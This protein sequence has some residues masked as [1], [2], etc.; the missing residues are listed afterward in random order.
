MTSGEPAVAGALS[1]LSNERGHYAIRAPGPGRYRLAA[2]RIGVKRTIVAPFDLAEGETR[3]VTI[4]I[5]QLLYALPEVSVTTATFCIP[6]EDQ[7]GRVASL[8]EE[9]R[10][11]LTATSISVRDTLYSGRI[12][13]FGRLLDG[14]G[15][16]LS[17]NTQHHDG[18]LRET[19]TSQAPESL[20]VYGYWSE[21][22]DTVRFH[23]PDVAVLLS[24]SFL[25][26]H[27]F[28][29]ADESREEAG[30][31]F[32]PAPGRSV[33]DVQG[34]IWVDARSFEL[35]RIEFTYTRLPVVQRVDGLGGE[36]HFARLNSGAWVVRRWYVRVPQF[37]LRS[38]R[39]PTME[40]VYGRPNPIRLQVNRV[41]ENRMLEHGGVAYVDNLR[42]FERPASISGVARDSTGAVFTPGIIRL[43]G[44]Q[45][46]SAV[47]VNGRFRIDSLP[48]GVYRV[49]VARDFHTALGTSA[50]EQDVTIEPGEDATVELKETGLD[51]LLARLCGGRAVARNR[52]ALRIVA[53]SG[54]DDQP[55]SGQPLRLWWTEY[56]PDRGLQRIV[57]QQLDG[58]TGADGSV[59]F[60]GLPVNVS[61]DLGLAIGPDRARRLET[62]RLTSRVPGIRTIRRD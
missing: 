32:R 55:D 40:R 42:I 47:D 49:E 44:T 11:A 8:W 2:K 38:N 46:A 14:R 26:D 51:G 43:A 6:R 50:A 28:E 37:A 60:C 59:V 3:E 52:T 22:G 20:S 17:E 7:V 39:G 13:S 54:T 27:C 41:V 48:P 1:V 36:V 34:T 9:V 19:F 45:Y 24:E 53:V 16:I 15:R 56:V 12:V 31:R 4:E 25:R 58:V 18:Q 61:I 21:E 10:T 29:L 33:G 5:E 62:L 35:R 30:L 57:Q 23:A